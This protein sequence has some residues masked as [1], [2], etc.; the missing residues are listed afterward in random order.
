MGCT[1][2]VLCT[3]HDKIYMTARVKDILESLNS[4]APFSL[5]ESWDNVGLLI[6][7]PEQEVTAVLAG[8]DPTNKL[9]G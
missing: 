6:G 9:S 2:F 1:F 8:L 5:A 7:N 4:E 3:L